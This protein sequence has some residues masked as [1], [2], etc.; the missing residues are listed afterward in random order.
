MLKMIENLVS[1]TAPIRAGIVFATNDDTKINGYDDAGVA[2][3]CSFNYVMQLKDAHEGL[4][5]IIEVS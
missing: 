5:F 3:V 4:N 2:M 1:H